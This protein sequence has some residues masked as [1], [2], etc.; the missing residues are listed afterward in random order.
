LPR[1]RDA[2]RLGLEPGQTVTLAN[3]RGRLAASVALDS[4][5]PAGTV[6]VRQAAE[7]LNVL[8]SPEVTPRG[9]SCINET[10]VDLLA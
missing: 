2:R 5:M 3:S 1:L 4:E 7:G 8:V 6:I 10:W 9:H